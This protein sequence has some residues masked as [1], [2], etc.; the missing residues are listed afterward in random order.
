M[1]LLLTGWSGFIGSHLLDRL[2]KKHDLFLYDNF[3]NPCIEYFLQRKD[4]PNINILPSLFSCS[5]QDYDIVF[6]I[7]GMG[8][9]PKSVQYFTESWE[10]NV[11]STFKILNN[12]N[13]K[14]FIFTSSSS[15]YGD[16]GTM[17]SP[18]LTDL[19]PKSPYALFKLHAEQLIKQF[20]KKYQILRLFNVYGPR[21]KLDYKY[22]A[23]MPKLI[24]N[25]QKI[26]IYNNGENIRSFTYI[27]DVVDIMEKMIDIDTP[28]IFNVC[29]QP[30]KVKKIVELI[31]PKSVEF[32]ADNRAMD[33]EKSIGSITDTTR[34]FGWEPKISIEDGIN[35][36]K[37]YYKK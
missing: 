36:T 19:N 14:R 24:D 10:A 34:V 37:L 16:Q 26:Y 33:I 18:Q 12:G 2:A 30:T 8:S 21:Q 35:K 31:E 6:H 29:S 27:D 15:V 9:A 25:K 32:I 17:V 23:L 3:T 20:T 5:Q 28:G 11:K 1:R 13:F 7:G 22:G 4:D